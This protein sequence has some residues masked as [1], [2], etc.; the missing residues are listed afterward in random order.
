MRDF[1]KIIS[2]RF[3]N[4]KLELNH[5]VGKTIASVTKM[6]KPQFDDEG[7]L[8][9]EFTDGTSCVIVASY[10]DYTGD[11]ENEYPTLIKI[12]NEVDGLVPLKQNS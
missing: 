3:M 4:K 9:L 6:K 1:K 5:L 10:Q 12:V 11:S 7:W 2:D 8:R